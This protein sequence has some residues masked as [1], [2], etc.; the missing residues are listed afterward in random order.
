MRYIRFNNLGANLR[1]RP[2][3]NPFVQA[4]GLIVGIIAFIGAIVVGGLVLAALVGFL[5]IAGLI[6]YLRVWWLAR[7]LRR[8]QRD[9]SIVEAEYQ[10]IDISKSDDDRAE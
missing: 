8:G 5:L 7:K 9:D 1:G 4:L 3:R 2:P 10:V 6:I